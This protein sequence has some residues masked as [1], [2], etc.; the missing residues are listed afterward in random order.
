MTRGRE[1]TRLSKT[2]R[3]LAPESCGW[4]C[5]A[6]SSSRPRTAQ[7]VSKPK[8]PSESAAPAGPA[9]AAAAAANVLQLQLSAATSSNA[10]MLLLI[11]ICKP[12]GAILSFESRTCTLAVCTPGR[13]CSVTPSS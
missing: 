6:C 9:E 5:R 12:A 3:R 11:Y 1:V 4:M 2:W 10:V 8:G 13:V 7:S